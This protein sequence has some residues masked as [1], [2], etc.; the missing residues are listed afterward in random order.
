MKR[1]IIRTLSTLAIASLA[2]ASCG[3]KTDQPISSTDDGQIDSSTP[4]TPETP[5]I[6][7]TIENPDYSAPGFAAGKISDRVVSEEDADVYIK[8]STPMEF[9]DAIKATYA[10]NQKA[11]KVIEITKDLDLGF[12]EIGEDVKAKYLNEGLISFVKNKAYVGS[13]LFNKTGVSQ[14]ELSNRQNLTIY[15]KNGATIRHAGFKITRCNDV[16]IRNI[17][18][19]EM[20]EWEDTATGAYGKIGDYDRH[21]W[22]YFK[23]NFS[24]NIWFD[25]CTFGKAYDGLIDSEN[26]S[27]G[28]AISWCKFLGG[29]ITEGSYIDEI[30]DEVETHY[31][32][33]KQIDNGEIVKPEGFDEEKGKYYAFLRDNGV[34]HDLILRA[35]C[36]G[37]KKGFLIGGGDT[38]DDN[39]WKTNKLMDFTIAN[40]Y[41]KNLQDRLPRVRGAN[42]Y[43]YNTVLDCETYY[44]ARQEIKG[45]A[46]YAEIDA[47]IKTNGWKMSLTSQGMVTTNEAAVKYKNVIFKG[48]S[49]AIKANNKDNS[50]IR[51][52][53]KYCVENSR[54]ILGDYSYTG[55]SGE[56]NTPWVNV[57]HTPTIDFRWNTEGGIIPFEIETINLDTLEATLLDS[58]YGSGSGVITLGDNFWLK[59][60]Y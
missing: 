30:M 4:T 6:P 31:N 11:I 21:G 59:A 15:S 47:G 25:H 36:Q 20:W 1:K 40:T 53:G 43:V 14:I 16:S 22:A 19:D 60:N 24:E 9:M 29:D 8:V 13:S 57:R 27:R 12:N 55:N 26:E 33:K 5:D 38:P 28:I 7:E 58:Q 46:N 10:E 34:S 42:A 49:E 44:S 37:Q 50:N 2:L 56:L 45:M 32:T 52:T 51:F 23:V 18:F 35:L 39:Q 41:I 48:V 17:N 3:E 54:Y